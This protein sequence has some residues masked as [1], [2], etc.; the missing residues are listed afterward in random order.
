M[1]KLY[2]MFGVSSALECK[3]K[4]YRLMSKIGLESNMENIMT[5]SEYEIEKI[6]SNVNLERLNNNPVRVS[7]NKLKEIF[8]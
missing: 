3:N 6:I 5:L 2:T 1:E 7:K 4:W 8:L